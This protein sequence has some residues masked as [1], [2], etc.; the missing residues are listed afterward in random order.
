MLG[1][2]G[3]QEALLLAV[4]S[5]ETVSSRLPELG[6][7]LRNWRLLTKHYPDLVGAYFKNALQN[8][9]H[10][11]K[12]SVWWTLSSAIEVLSVSRPA[13]VLE[14]ALKLGPTDMIHPVLSDWAF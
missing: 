8:A 1:Q 6:Y 12:I 5:E 7:A 9:T 14:C 2:W 13:I 11:E 4:C 10:R 3:A